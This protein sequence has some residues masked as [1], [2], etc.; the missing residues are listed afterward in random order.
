MSPIRLLLFSRFPHAEA[1][2]LA[3]I[4]SDP[5][6]ILTAR[7]ASL[8]AVLSAY[9]VY[10]PDVVVLDADTAPV[11][12]VRAVRRQC[13]AVKVLVCGPSGADARDMLYA[14]AA[15]YLLCESASVELVGAV[16]SVY[17]G[18]VAVSL[19]LTRQLLG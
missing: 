4:R 13:P 16:R 1:S 3:A 8:P 17:A 2:L 12:V 9:A 19:A 11:D 10:S 5:E 7:A 18:K 15:G 6:L 14:G